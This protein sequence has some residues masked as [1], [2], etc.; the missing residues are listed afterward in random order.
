MDDPVPMGIVRRTELRDQH[1]GNHLTFLGSAA[2][3][4]PRVIPNAFP[5]SLTSDP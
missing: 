3:R 5:S 4:H 2:P 1:R